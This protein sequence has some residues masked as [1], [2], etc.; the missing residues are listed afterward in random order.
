MA[1]TSPRSSGSLGQPS[2]LR[3]ELKGYLM[4]L[5]VGV[6]A[7]DVVAIGLY[8]A[9]HIRDRPSN[10]QQVFVAVWMVLTLI[11]VTTMMKR[12]R[13]ARRRRV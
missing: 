10:T 5:V 9:L 2:A 1:M 4:K 12:I 13:Q 8:Y 11:I 3:R 7:L 6:A